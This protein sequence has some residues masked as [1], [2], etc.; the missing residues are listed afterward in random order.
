MEVRVNKKVL[1]NSIKEAYKL[2]SKRA[3]APFLNSVWI[4]AEQNKGVFIQFTDSKIEYSCSIRGAIKES[5]LVGIECKQLVDLLKSLPDNMVKIYKDNEQAVIQQENRKFNLE[6]YD[7][8][9][10]MGYTPLPDNPIISLP[11]GKLLEIIEK[12]ENSIKKDDGV[13]DPMDHMNIH[14]TENKVRFCAING[15]QFSMVEIENKQL[16]ELIK[17]VVPANSISI[18]GKRIQKLKKLIKKT[19]CQLT[20]DDDKV[21]F[22]KNENGPFTEQN[23]KHST[24]LSVPYYTT[25]WVDYQKFFT[26]FENKLS[27]LKIDKDNLLES[28]KIMKGFINEYNECFVFYPKKN[29]LTIKFQNQVE[30]NIPARYEGELEKISFPIPTM[31][32]NLKRIH[33][34]QVLFKF[35]GENRPCMI[36]GTEEN[37]HTL[38]T[39][40]VDMEEDKFSN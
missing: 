11:K 26:Y 14:V 37:E 40:P 10:S 2:Y 13:D 4:K 28:L 39:M 32:D 8:T 29:Q 7:N 16:Q 33:S 30:E 15:F 31:I 3:S 1:E 27:E 18:H 17:E 24:I 5:G 9:W 23:L 12:T 22:I 34:K 38:I 19:D 6:T 20:I 21:Y 35:T 36:Q 25:Q